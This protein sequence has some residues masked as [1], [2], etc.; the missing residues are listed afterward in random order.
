[1]RLQI[2]FLT[3]SVQNAAPQ[4]A[5]LFSQTTAAPTTRTMMSSTFTKICIES[6]ALDFKAGVCARA[7]RLLCACENACARRRHTLFFWVLRA[8]FA[9]WRF[10]LIC[11]RVRAVVSRSRSSN[12]VG[13]IGNCKIR[14]EF[15]TIE[16]DDSMTILDSTQL[17]SSSFDQF[18][19]QQRRH[20]HQ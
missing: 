13:S 12:S 8:R 19:R 20:S 11:L 1:M 7:F 16:M 17:H 14:N 2:E 3:L 15:A 18:A 5:F 6:R 9:R 10:E 4:A